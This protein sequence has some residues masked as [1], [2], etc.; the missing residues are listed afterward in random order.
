MCGLPLKIAILSCL[1]ACCNC[2]NISFCTVCFGGLLQMLQYPL[3]PFGPVATATLVSSL[4]DCNCNIIACH[5]AIEVWYSLSLIVAHC[6]CNNVCFYGLL[7]LQ[8]SLF[9]TLCNTNTSSFHAHCSCNL[10]LLCPIA[11]VI[12]LLLAM[13]CNKIVWG[14]LL[15]QHFWGH[16]R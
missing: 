8:H 3:Y 15:L 5:G 2:N 1:V 16:C 4:V 7:Q 11:I 12:Q 6:N 14:A 13:H 10:S 9:M